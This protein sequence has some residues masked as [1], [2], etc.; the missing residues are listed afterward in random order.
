MNMWVREQTIMGIE[1]SDFQASKRLA[2]PAF[3]TFIGTGDPAKYAKT[4][5]LLWLGVG[6][7]EPERMRTGLRNLHNSLQEANISHVYYESPGTDHEWQT[8]RHDL[9]DFSSRLFQ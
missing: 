8:R 4:V 7:N 2:P 1:L 5:Q 9:K 6:T 3:T